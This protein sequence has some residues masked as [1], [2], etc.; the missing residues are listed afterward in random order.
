M[1]L[2]GATTRMDREIVSVSQNAVIRAESE[3]LGCD[4][5]DSEAKTPF[6]QI[7][8]EFRFYQGD[9]VLYILPVLATCPNCREAID[10]M[11]CVAPRKLQ[12]TVARKRPAL[13]GQA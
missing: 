2:Q 7:L 9:Q 3:I 13:R 6:W 11:T 10:E 12:K 8:N 4:R 5:C 1:T